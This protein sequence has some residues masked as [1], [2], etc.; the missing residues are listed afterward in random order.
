MRLCAAI[1]GRIERIIEHGAAQADERRVAMLQRLS[2][3]PFRFSKARMR[4]TST[5]M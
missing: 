1:H 3:K 2:M 5:A 4:R